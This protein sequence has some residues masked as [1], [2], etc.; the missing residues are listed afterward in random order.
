MTNNKALTISQMLKVIHDFEI[1]S[2]D[3]K[4]FFES[5]KRYLMMSQTS[6]EQKTRNV[7]SMKF[8]QHRMHHFAKIHVMLNFIAFDL[9]ENV[10]E[11]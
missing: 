8:S 4:Y 1:L 11:L 9:S 10:K 2:D 7:I 3:F 5:Q 6:K